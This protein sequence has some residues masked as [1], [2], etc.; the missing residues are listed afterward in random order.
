MPGILDEMGALMTP[1]RASDRPPAPVG[2]WEDVDRVGDDFR[3]A[4]GKKL[5]VLSGVAVLVS[6]A[7]L[8]VGDSTIRVFGGV[9]LAW[10]LLAFVPAVFIV[11]KA[12]NRIR[13]GRGLV[14][15]DPYR[16]DGV[17]SSPPGAQS[18]K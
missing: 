18:D 14:P 13:A 7:L 12:R 15:G 1:D 8:I 16:P 5:L 2:R 10:S 3:L 4:R 9:G 6:V 17:A 11:S